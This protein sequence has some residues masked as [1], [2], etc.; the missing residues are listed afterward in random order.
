M[1]KLL[2]LSLVCLWSHYTQAQL[3]ETIQGGTPISTSEPSGSESVDPLGRINPENVA[4]GGQ[5][6]PTV[7]MLEEAPVPGMLNEE[8]EIIRK[9]TEERMMRLRNGEEP[10][11]GEDDDKPTDD[12]PS[13]QPGTN[14][15]IINESYQIG[16]ATL[17]P[18]DN[19]MAISTGGK[20]VNSVNSRVMFYETDG[21]E[22]FNSSLSDFFA[23]VAPNAM[24]YDP[25]VI[26]M[27]SYD[28]FAII[29]C[30]G[31]TSTTSRMFVAFSST[32]NPMDTWW[33]YSFNGTTCTS[34]TGWFDYPIIGASTD[35][36]VTGNLFNNSNNFIESI[37]R[38]INLSNAF[39]GGTVNSSWWCNVNQDNGAL[40]NSIN[41]LSY[42]YG[43]IY[44]PGI[45]LA[46]TTLQNNANRIYY[47]WIT[48]NQA[49]SPLLQTYETSISSYSPASNAP[50]NGSTNLLDT[51]GSRMRDGFYADGHL[52]TV[53]TIDR[54][55]GEAGIRYVKTNFASGTSTVSSTFGVNG[56]DYAYPVIQPW[57]TN[58]ATWDGGVVIAFLRSSPFVF[59][60]FRGVYVNPSQVFSNSFLIKIGESPIINGT[61]SRWGDYIEG[62]V[63]VNGLQPE[64]WFS[65][66]YGRNNTYG[67]WNVQLLVNV[68]GCTNASACNYNPSATLDDGSCETSS[69]TGCMNQSACNYNPNATIAGFCFF[70]GCNQPSACN[71]N[72]LAGC[73]DG[74]CCFDN[75][76]Q[77]NMFD[78][79][80]DGWNGGT[81]T[82]T[83]GNGDVVATGTLDDGSQGTAN[84]GC[85]DDGCYSFTVTAGVFPQEITWELLYTFGSSPMFPIPPIIF[86]DG[87]APFSDNIAIGDGSENDG[88]TDPMACNFSQNAICDDGSCCYQNCLE[89]I[90]T[91][92]FGDGWNGN[93]WE[94][95]DPATNTV[96]DSGTLENGS[97]GTDFGCV[98]AGCYLFRINTSNGVFAAEVGWTLNGTDQG[99]F[100]GGSSDQVSFVIGGGAPNAGCTDVNACNFDFNADCDDGSC[101]YDLCSQIAMFD[102]FG[103]GWNGAIL[104][105]FDENNIA[106]ASTTMT[107]GS[108]EIQ[109][110]CLSQG[111]FTITVSSG[112]FPGEVSW[113][114]NA[115]GN[116][117]G[118]GAP[119]SG[120]FTI[121]GNA[122]CTDI[123]ACNYNGS[124]I[125][126]DASCVYPGCVDPSACNFS[127]NAVCDD[128]S[129]SY[130]CYGCTYSD[131]S[132]FMNGATIDDGTCLFNN[133]ENSCPAD[134][135]Q[136]GV[137]NSSD[138]SIF[139]SA[140][141]TTCS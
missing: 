104:T 71:Y 123:S 33:T 44:G 24:V 85:L 17:S 18:P 108:S 105:V 39:T 132:N 46:N 4:K 66:Q 23:P 62:C 28:R 51:G 141:G 53:W 54:N 111:C 70:P 36:Y 35:L 73:D 124:A 25:R 135:N 103:D 38:Q 14:T 10:I 5:W 42:A 37:I 125:C 32:N 34:G 136:D 59:P 49:N 43:A 96:V 13:Q 126:D 6:N 97:I 134:L 31:T 79:F 89:I 116:F 112:I 1:K 139:L 91:D 86:A 84:L 100:S 75:C 78:D 57:G 26:Y 120:S 68:P 63:R 109:S 131:A 118:G 12:A 117:I 9:K 114:L 56:S 110:L 121:G 87:G 29:V 47:Y 107:D 102:S 8:K 99:S 77:I 98:T 72:W 129:C 127:L 69:C 19:A 101:C 80:G 92:S 83:D 140:F 50:Q 30:N 64:V 2:A 16:N 41:P 21:T 22:L 95:L 45:V 82:L 94:I 128:G 65:G 130:A 48:Q 3:V 137:I 90:M 88:C 119:F 113:L 93:I 15:P 122:G 76:V 55:N 60:Q 115:G 58:L 74:S 52:Y 67:N 7:K 106:V 133:C 27:P 81:F 138:L 11:P 20:I 61:T 40:A